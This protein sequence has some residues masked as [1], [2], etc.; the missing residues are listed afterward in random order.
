[1]DGVQ[2]LEFLHQEPRLK[3]VPVIALTA[4]A[5]TGDREQLLEAGFDEYVAKPIVDEAILFE[6]IERLLAL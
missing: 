4:H 3:Q 6:A 1:M 2:V 5:M